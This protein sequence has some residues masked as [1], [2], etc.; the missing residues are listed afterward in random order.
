MID[1]EITE[2]IEELEVGMVS[3]GGL[4]V[5]PDAAVAV[6]EYPGE[7]S[8]HVKRQK[9]PVLEYPRIQVMVRAKGYGEARRNIER[10]YRHLT[11]YAGTLNGTGYASIRALQPPY[12]AG[13]DDRSRALFSCNFRI[14]KQPSA[15]P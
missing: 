7:P 13:R 6:W 14:S 5:T 10:I 4:P 9:E 8:L 12:D 3:V 15:I 1:S 11:G 2:L